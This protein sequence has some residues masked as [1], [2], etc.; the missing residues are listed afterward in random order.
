MNFFF[1]SITCLCI[2]FSSTKGN[3]TLS[4]DITAGKIKTTTFAISGNSQEICNKVKSNLVLTKRFK[5]IEC[6]TDLIKMQKFGVDLFIKIVIM[7]DHIR[8]EIFDILQKKQIKTINI[9]IEENNN[10]NSFKEE[11]FTDLISNIVY[12]AWFNEEGIFNTKIIFASAIE[13]NLT[14][15]NSLNYTDEKSKCISGPISYLES[16]TTANKMIYLTKFSTQS[17]GFAI[18]RF[19]LKLKKFFKVAS[20][21]NTSIFSPFVESDSLYVS[22]SKKGTTSIYIL[23]NTK[24]NLKFKTFSE[25]EKESVMIKKGNKTIN[26]GFNKKNEIEVYTSDC[27]GR[28]AILNKQNKKISS[29]NGVYFEPTLFGKEKIAAIKI[30]QKQFHLVTIDLKTSEE[31][32]LLS[33]Y[34]IGKPSWSPCGNWIA[35]SCKNRFEKEKI[36]LIHKTGKYTREIE[37]E[38][39]LKNPVWITKKFERS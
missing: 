27:F 4:I 38:T 37:G 25:F 22:A 23:P 30:F 29:E 13:P 24:S 9:S 35:V 14:C 6:E 1:L 28:P 32:I 36:I 31:K 20:I 11:A 34:Y 12:Q 17:R 16:L 21:E 2:F 3:S 26:T 15:L 10:F 19:N 18:F 8:L 5:N 39:D 7:Q 33:K